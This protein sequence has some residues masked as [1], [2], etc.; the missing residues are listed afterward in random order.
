MNT[1]IVDTFNL[2]RFD[3]GVTE[4]CRLSWQTSSALV[5]EPKCVREEGGH[6]TVLI[7]FTKLQ[8]KTDE[9][10]ELGVLD[11]P[12]SQLSPLS[13]VTVQAA[14]YIIWNR[15]HPTV[16]VAWRAGTAAP[17]SGLS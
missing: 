2:L 14:V 11:E 4:R 9:C 16:Y 8:E 15:V 3:Q 5:Y 7:I 6:L 1:G 13:G 17:L 10:P 12:L